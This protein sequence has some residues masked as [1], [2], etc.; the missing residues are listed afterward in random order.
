MI[1]PGAVAHRCTA[2]RSSQL[3]AVVSGNKRN[4]DTT[5]RIQRRCRSSRQRV[6]HPGEQGSHDRR[7]CPTRH[8]PIS[9]RVSVSF[10]VRSPHTAGQPNR[11]RPSFR[12]RQIPVVRRPLQSS[13]AL[14]ARSACSG[15]SSRPDPLIFFSA[16]TTSDVI[17]HSGHPAGP[18]SGV[19]GRKHQSWNSPRWAS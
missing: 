10:S 13:I 15:D 5:T 2:G 19:S 6:P 11:S 4:Q 18:R 8:R 14:A 9:T 12:R 7:H 16:L 1:T 3:P 17:T